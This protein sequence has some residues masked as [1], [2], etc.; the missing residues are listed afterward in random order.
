MGLRE[1]DL[2]DMLVDIFEIDSYASKMGDDKD[3]ITLSF[4]LKEKA[5]ADDLMNFLEKGYGFILDADVTAGEQH[6]GTYKV[7]VE[8]ERN[9]EAHQ[10]ILELADGVKKLSGLTE[11]KFRYYKNFRSRI[12]D[13][14]NLAEMVPVDPNEYGLK[15]NESNL[16][17]YKNFFNRSFLD[18]VEMVNE[19][20]T[21]K[22]K[23]ADPLEFEFVDFGEAE[24]TINKINEKLDI[25]NG[26][27][28]ILFLTKYIG[29]YNI[30]KYGSKIVFE[31]GSKALVLKRVI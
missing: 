24:H 31:N 30:S 29:A 8:I 6:D 13:E 5:P 1:N 27:P 3:I 23:Y 14:S 22:K 21:I 10:N 19:T 28:E 7:F 25:M 9:K 26:Y 20:L 15:V 17:N 18:S 16:D 11:L 4:S 2:H 12:A